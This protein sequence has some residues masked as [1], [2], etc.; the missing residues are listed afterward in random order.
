MLVVFSGSLE[1]LLHALIDRFDGNGNFFILVDIV[2]GSES[3]DSDGKRIKS[4]LEIFL[5]L[6]HLLDEG[7]LLFLKDL[8]LTL[9][10]VHDLDWGSI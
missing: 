7:L 1:A 5:L 4:F 8:S 9:N 10:G 3:S 2:I 6:F